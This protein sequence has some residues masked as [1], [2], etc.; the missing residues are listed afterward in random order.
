MELE[1]FNILEGK[2]NQAV[3]FIEQLRKENQEIK[4]EVNELRSECDSKDLVIQQ[5]KE[6]N[7]NLKLIQNKSILGEEK[8]EKI[9]IK[10][11]QMLT[12]LDELQYL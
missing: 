9:R 8:E 10:V 2:I 11:E 7:Q 12:K 1:Q 3:R 6:E 4:S 5:L